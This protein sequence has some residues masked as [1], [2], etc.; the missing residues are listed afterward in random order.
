[1]GY[2]IE[3]EEST[4]KIHEDFV[5]D[6][7]NKIRKFAEENDMRW[8]D[9]SILK[10][11]G[12]DLYSIFEE[13]RHP[14]AKVGGYYEIDYFDGEKIGDE[15]YLFKEI[16]EYVEA[17]SYIEYEGEDRHRFRYV[18]DGKTCKEVEAKV[19]VEWE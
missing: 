6:V 2:C 18:F 11:S 17:G 9:M 8:V 4:F 12:N 10:D 7:V 3:M 19:T 14:L 15:F 13:L 1:M 5:G 16:A